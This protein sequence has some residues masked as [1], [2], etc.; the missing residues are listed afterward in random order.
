MIVKN[1]PIFEKVAKR[2]AEAKKPSIQNSKFFVS[3]SDEEKRF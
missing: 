2:V 1:L 3:L